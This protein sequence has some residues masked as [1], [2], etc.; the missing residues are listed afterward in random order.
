MRDIEWE[1]KKENDDSCM[2][3]NE[4]MNRQVFLENKIS[5]FEE[6]RFAKIPNVLNVRL[7]KLN[8]F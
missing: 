4:Q 8:L 7:R 6:D 2:W 1:I 3:L 5:S